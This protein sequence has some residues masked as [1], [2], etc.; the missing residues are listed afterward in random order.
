MAEPDVTLPL[1]ASDEQPIASSAEAYLKNPIAGREYLS[2][3]EVVDAISLLSAML[4]G[5]ERYRLEMQ[6]R[7]RPW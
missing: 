4:V 2:P 3:L 5:D 7:A 6:G 1:S